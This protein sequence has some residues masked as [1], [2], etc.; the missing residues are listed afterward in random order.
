LVRSGPPA[1]ALWH[2]PFLLFLPDG[3]ERAENCAGFQFQYVRVN[4][5]GRKVAETVAF[6]I[7]DMPATLV[8][9]LCTTNI[10][11]NSRECR[12]E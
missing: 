10:I 4:N 5:R 8:Q 1:F 3:V 2:E 7:T 9:C 12:K 6:N 11:E